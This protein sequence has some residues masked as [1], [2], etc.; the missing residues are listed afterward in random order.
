MANR[1]DYREWLRTRLG[2][3]T[4]RQQWQ[5]Q[6]DLGLVPAPPQPDPGVQPSWDLTVTNSMLNQCIESAAKTAIRECRVA[7]AINF[8]DLPVSA[9]ASTDTGPYTFLL[10]SIPVFGGGDPVRLRRSYWFD[11]TTYQQ[12][13]PANLSQ[14]DVQNVDYLNNGPGT[15]TQIAI[16]GNLVYL[17]P[18]PQTDGILRLTVGSGALAPLTDTEGY[19]GVADSY[20]DAL[21]YI[22]LVELAA[23]LTS[24]KEMAQRAAAF[25][26][27]AAKS[28]QDL[29]AWFDNLSLDEFI[30]SS[31]F[32]T[33]VIRYSRRA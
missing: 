22:A 17:M 10:S 3:T 30:P 11:G 7:N 29:T 9:M 4:P 18:G 33:S 28:I 19:D 1:A 12:V 21:N 6:D 32:Q 14:L 24:N 8:T 20:A 31:T 23:M 15:P 2:I 25:A 27:M 13:M 5:L 16:E 26:P